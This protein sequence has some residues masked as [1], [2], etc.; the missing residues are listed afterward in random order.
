MTAARPIP[1]PAAKHAVPAHLNAPEAALYG[2]IVK[3]YGLRDT[4]SL[5]IL[6]EACASL[7]RARLAREQIEREGMT[8]LD[9]KNQPKMHPC[10]AVERDARHA[11]LAAFRQLNLEL[12]RKFSSL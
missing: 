12:P 7:Q 3:S 11:A 6:E 2:D 8:F 10:C 1:L 4:A 9:T 5:K